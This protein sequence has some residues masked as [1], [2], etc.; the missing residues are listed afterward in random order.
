MHT[1]VV[2]ALLRVI[3]A[4]LQSTAV[5]LGRDGCCFGA[6]KFGPTTFLDTNNI[7]ACSILIYTQVLQAF[8]NLS[9]GLSLMLL[10]F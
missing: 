2:L 3:H 4:F 9:L 5:V 10:I 6:I 7:Y 1:R 8:A